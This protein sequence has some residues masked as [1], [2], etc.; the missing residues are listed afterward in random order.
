M[1]VNNTPY[2]VYSRPPNLAQ[3]MMGGMATPHH[4]QGNPQ[5]SSQINTLQTPQ[6][7]PLVAP[8]QQV[9]PVAGSSSVKKI[10]MGG[11][12]TGQSG[13]HPGH[14]SKVCNLRSRFGCLVLFYRLFDLL[15]T[16]PHRIVAHKD[17]SLMMKIHQEVL[18]K[19]SSD[20]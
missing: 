1:S 13:S 10:K 6:R 14:V 5:H 2:R 19:Q 16:R 17:R 12:G 4:F 3:P 18:N 20:S 8:Q 7:Y 15:C 11:S 9:Y